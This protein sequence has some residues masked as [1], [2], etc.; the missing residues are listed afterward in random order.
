MTKSFIS[1]T[2]YTWNP[3]VGC[4]KVSEGCKYCYMHRILSA[5]G[6]SPSVVKRSADRQFYK[7]YSIPAR[8]MVFTCSMSDFFHE[9]IDPYRNELWKIIRE[10]P[11]LIYQILTKR[12]ERI[13]ECLPDDW[14]EGYPHV[15]LG[16]SVE[17]QKWMSRAAIL[18]DIP[19]AVR[20]L[21]VEP[22][23]EEIDLLEQINGVR[24]IDKI[25]WVIA[26]GES[27]HE[28]GQY[29]YRPSE[30]GWYRRICTDLK[31]EAPHTAIFVKQ[32]GRHISKLHHL[33]DYKGE[34][35]NEFPADLRIQEYPVA[36]RA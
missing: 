9:S 27:G 13:L 33:K 23:L 3:F 11:H 5:E 15:W 17:S 12:P 30:I 29:R 22:I 32:L 10:T 14:G 1:W 7:P 16:T 36:Q 31:R 19:A 24:P 21:S 34:D 2:E 8:S 28:I 25:H 26:G 35:I 6:N 18:S 4:S 20:F